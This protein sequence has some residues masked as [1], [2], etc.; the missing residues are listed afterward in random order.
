MVTAKD[1]LDRLTGTCIPLN[2]FLNINN[3]KQC[4]LIMNSNLHLLDLVLTSSDL[5][6]NVQ[7]CDNALVPEDKHHPSLDIDVNISVA[8]HEVKFGKY[9]DTNDKMKY[10]FRKG[11]YVQLYDAIATKDW[12]QI[13]SVKDVNE[14]CDLF[15]QELDALL[16]Y[17]VPKSTVKLS[18]YPV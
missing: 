16:D 3:L 7:R 15:H 11:N 2:E 17:S 9:G 6:C 12:S 13:R 5:T 8:N 18:T 10:N 14:A 4:N 1:E